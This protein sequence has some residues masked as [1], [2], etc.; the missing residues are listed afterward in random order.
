M[1]FFLYRPNFSG[2]Q[3]HFMLAR[4]FHPSL[5]L[6]VPVGFL[7]QFISMWPK[8][9]KGQADTQINVNH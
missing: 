4:T 9:I 5:I 7:I 1:V 3:G 6:I 8:P 2:K